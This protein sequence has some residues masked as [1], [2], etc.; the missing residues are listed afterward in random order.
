M[1]NLRASTVLST[2]VDSAILLYE[3]GRIDSA[4]SL[5]LTHGFPGE[6]AQRVFKYPELRRKYI[7]D[8]ISGF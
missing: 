2:I 6:V 3:A 1:D 8:M 7:N 5:L 4:Y